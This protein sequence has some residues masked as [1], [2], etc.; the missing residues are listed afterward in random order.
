MFHEIRELRSL[1][2]SASAKYSF[3]NRIY[4]G[5]KGFLHG[6][7]STQADKTVEAVEL[8]DSLI[9]QFPQ[10]PELIGILKNSFSESINTSRPA[11]RGIPSYGYSLIEQG[12]KE[13]LRKILYDNID[14]FNMDSINRFHDEFIKGR[15]LIFI[16][17]GN[18]SKMGVDKLKL[19]TQKLRLKDILTE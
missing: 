12:Y 10:K 13:D 2:Y 6:E 1:S 9:K 7:L 4:A 11:F 5:F 8:A 3:P 18:E 15:P 19:R 17:T 14:M 16:L